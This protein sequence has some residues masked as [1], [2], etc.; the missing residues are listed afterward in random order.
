MHI[1]APRSIFTGVNKLPPAHRLE[2]CPHEGLR[3]IRYWQPDFS[4]KAVC[5]E[6]EWLELIDT[7]LRQAI[8]ERLIADVPLGALLSGG[9][10]SSLIVALMSEVAGRPIPTISMGFDEQDFNEL[11]YARRVAEIYST[12]HYE[13]VLQPR[14]A[15]VLPALVFHYGEPFADDS[16]LPTYYLT[17]AAREHVTV[18]LTGD[19]GDENFAGYPRTLAMALAACSLRY[20]P[21]LLRE[22]LATA[23]RTMER[24]GI[25]AVRKL[26]WAAEFA[27][28]PQGGYRFDPLGDRTFRYWDD[29]LYGPA[30]MTCTTL[31]KRDGLYRE[32]WDEAGE[33]DWVDRALYVDMLVFLPGHLMTKID[34]A[35]MA[36]GLEARAP[37]LDLRMLELTARIPA[38]LKLRH[39]HTKY[40]LKRLA[41]RYLPHE[42][43]YKRK[44]GFGLP[45][46]SWLRRDMGALLCPILLSDVACKR[47]YFRPEAVAHFINQHRSGTTDHG[48][49]LW[50][51]LMLELWFRMFIDRDIAPDD[52]LFA[53]VS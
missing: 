2:F 12:E 34:V 51:L 13:H 33:I 16:A 6:D 20:S 44:Q 53:L 3:L 10:D 22:G 23:L 36:H 24:R 43:L 47:G 14:A 25:R 5:S 48:Q 32:L 52:D 4:A 17:K 50:L 18:V 7:T 39:W 42:L 45:T 11:P 46:A 1:P 41:E 30:L 19:G 35:S 29:G 37:F 27:R 26:R 15:A 31:T 38:R 9:V 21:H 49:R 28:G 8:R 40:L